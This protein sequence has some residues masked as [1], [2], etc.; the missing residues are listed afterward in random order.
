MDSLPVKQVRGRIP[1]APDVLPC[2]RNTCS[3][4]SFLP[5]RRGLATRR[6]C[7]AALL[8]CMPTDRQ[9]ES[10][11]V[12]MSTMHAQPRQGVETGAA[13][14]RQPSPQYWLTVIYASLHGVPCT[15]TTL[16]LTPLRS[17]LGVP[18]GVCAPTAGLARLN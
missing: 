8:L 14:P 2:S 15:D 1:W 12:A 13:D 3:P 7:C 9:D 17:R 18:Q 6:L 5:P 16:W 4:S 11:A 10:R